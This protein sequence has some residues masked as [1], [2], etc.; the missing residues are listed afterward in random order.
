M[1][2]FF[3]SSAISVLCDGFATFLHN[4]G[5]MRLVIN[6]IL[7]EDDKTAIEVGKGESLIPTF[8]LTNIEQI[9]ETLSEREGVSK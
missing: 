9:I 8:D 1:L 3:S 2:G 7:T 6:D 4:G 5:R